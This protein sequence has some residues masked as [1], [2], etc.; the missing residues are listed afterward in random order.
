MHCAPSALSG[1]A[2]LSYPF[3][4]STAQVEETLCINSQGHSLTHPKEFELMNQRVKKKLVVLAITGAPIAFIAGASSHYALHRMGYEPAPWFAITWMI[5]CGFAGFYLA[6]GIIR[7]ER[8][9]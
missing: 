6:C 3:W 9:S 8:G 1:V 2:G 4:P 5:G 7:K